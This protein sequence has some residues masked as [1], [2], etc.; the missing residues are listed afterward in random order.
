MKSFTWNLFFVVFSR[1]FLYRVIW[2]T[3]TMVMKPQTDNT[4]SHYKASQ[5]VNVKMWQS[6]LNVSH[7][8]IVCYADFPVSFA[9]FHGFTDDSNQAQ[10]SLK[11]L[12][13][14]YQS[15]KLQCFIQEIEQTECW[16][17]LHS[18]PEIW[19]NYFAKYI[20]VQRG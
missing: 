16:Q 14:T 7:N 4:F 8:N 3:C 18:F 20:G 9:C 6:T 15:G 10:Q 1:F 19:I 2:N 13:S 5:S 12:I 11:S 17:T